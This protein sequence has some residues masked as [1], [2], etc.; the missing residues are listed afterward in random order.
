MATSQGLLAKVENL[1]KW[2]EQIGGKQK[3]KH[4]PNYTGAWEMTRRYKANE[5]PITSLWMKRQ[6]LR[7]TKMEKSW[8]KQIWEQQLLHCYLR[9]FYIQVDR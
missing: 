6:E 3:V 4:G 2:G 5:L 7:I 1:K 9:G 8:G